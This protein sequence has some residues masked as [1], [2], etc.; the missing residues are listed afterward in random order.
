MANYS[1]RLQHVDIESLFDKCTWYIHNACRIA[2]NV[3]K[4]IGLA[5]RHVLCF[6]VN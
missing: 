4:H 5:Q 2:E 1:K 6:D 3:S